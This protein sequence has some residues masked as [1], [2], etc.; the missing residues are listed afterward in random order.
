[1]TKVLFVDDEPYILDTY[2][3]MLRGSKFECSVLSDSTQLFELP[4]L[5]YVDIIVVDQQM[6]KITG[7]ELLLKMKQQFPNIKRVLVS[8]DIFKLEGSYTDLVLQKPLMKL[9]LIKCLS[10]LK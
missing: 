5:K 9:E 10:S 7:S 2:L 4:N 3:R 8:A 6:P 1:M